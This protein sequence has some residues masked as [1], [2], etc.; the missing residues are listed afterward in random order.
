MQIFNEK[1][2]TNSLYI[3]SVE[4]R[5]LVIETCGPDLVD[6]LLGVSYLHLD[7]LLLSHQRSEFLQLMH[8]SPVDIHL[9]AASGKE[10]LVKDAV[11]FE[12]ILHYIIPCIIRHVPWIDGEYP[13][14]DI[15]ERQTYHL[16]T[17]SIGSNC[18][19]QGN[20]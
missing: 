6:A 2:I 14:V 11:T 20:S 10:V 15:F 1:K 8:L 16:T 12:L 18:Y 17:F 3:F 9:L 5:R 13:S 19:P 4:E 7:F